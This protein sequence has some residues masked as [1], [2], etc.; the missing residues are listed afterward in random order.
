MIGKCSGPFT[1]EIKV[2]WQYFKRKKNH[3]CRMGSISLHPQNLCVLNN[4]GSTGKQLLGGNLWRLEIAQLRFWL[5]KYSD[6][7]EGSEQ[8]I[9]T[10]TLSYPLS[11]SLSRSHPPN[12]TEKVLY[13]TISGKVGN[14]SQRFSL[15]VIG[16]KNRNFTSEKFLFTIASF[17]SSN[18]QPAAACLSCRRRQR[19]PRE[20]FEGA[21]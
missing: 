6:K 20:L 3:L 5:L 10:A 21:D 4:H 9:S 12:V 17:F 19:C 1:S 7:S 15:I 8:Y 16:V 13:S 14:A 18:R 11:L 2:S